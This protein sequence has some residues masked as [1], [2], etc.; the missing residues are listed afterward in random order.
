MLRRVYPLYLRIKK[1]FVKTS[2]IRALM[3][4]D[5]VRARPFSLLTFF[6][7]SYTSHTNHREVEKRRYVECWKERK[8]DYDRWILRT[9]LRYDRSR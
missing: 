7:K 8:S 4:G 3:I 2:T 9:D 1:I 6:L 5:S